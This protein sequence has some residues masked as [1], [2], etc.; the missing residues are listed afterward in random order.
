MNVEKANRIH[1]RKFNKIC[2]QYLVKQTITQNEFIQEAE[3]LKAKLNKQK[4]T[5]AGIRD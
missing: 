5:A 4:Y 2:E 1:D 3:K